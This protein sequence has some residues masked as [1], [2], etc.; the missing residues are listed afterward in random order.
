V[1]KWLIFCGV[2]L[3]CLC[4]EHIALAVPGYGYALS[5]DGVDDYVNIN[6]N[7]LLSVTGQVT[8]EAWVKPES[9]LSTYQ[10]IARKGN[11]YYLGICD[12]NPYCR[13]YT[14]TWKPV[15][16]SSVLLPDVWYHLAMTYNKNEGSSEA[17]LSNFDAL[18]QGPLLV[19]CGSASDWDANMRE[20]GNVLYEPNYPDTNQKYK[21]FYSGYNGDYEE[22]NVYIGYAYS[23]DGNNWTKVGKIISRSGEDPYVVD[24]NGAY[25]LY[26]EDKGWGPFHKG[27][28]LY[29]SNDCITWTDMGDVFDIQGGGNPPD[30]QTQDVSSPL[31]WIDNNG[32]W[33][34]L[35][36]GR[37][38]GNEGLIGLAT[39]TDGI[40]WTRDGNDPVM[41]WGAPGTWDESSVVPDDIMKI[42]D[43]YYLLYHGCSYP[44][45]MGYWAGLA[46]SV[47]LHTWN[48]YKWNPIQ[49]SVHDGTL[50]FAQDGHYGMVG[51]LD[52]Y[53][54]TAGIYRYRP[55]ITSAPHLYVNGV[56][57]Y[58]G[59][60]D[61]NNAPIYTDKYGLTIGRAPPGTGSAYYYTGLIDDVF[62]WSRALDQNEIVDSMNGNMHC[63]EPNLIAYWSFDEPNGYIA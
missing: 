42:G 63:P 48:R 52:T 59:R 55:Y 31:V 40:N 13:I 1:N 36:E 47:D 49:M 3:L 44:N 4:H 2:G 30:W 41:G 10:M 54:S 17:N 25:Y 18:K 53:T 14:N 32:V 61:C 57:S 8:L 35:Y 9:F 7:P 45:K 28:R 58:I 62:L 16:S 34:L 21:A 23:A 22:N 60:S 20:I 24:N 46:T 43:T 37:G 11:A 12:K 5:F 56:E 19:P 29:I 15:T 39:S 51:A 6:Y 50:M 33:Y 26:M 38:N 27:I